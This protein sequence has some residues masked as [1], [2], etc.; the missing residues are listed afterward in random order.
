MTGVSLSIHPDVRK[1]RDS[2]DVARSKAAA[3]AIGAM[4]CL[5]SK[6]K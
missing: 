1:L 5:A 2:R 6:P 3:D 4:N